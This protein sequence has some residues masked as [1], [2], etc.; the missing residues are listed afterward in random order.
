MKRGKNPTHGER[1]EL[2]AQQVAR[3]QRVPLSEAR[4]IVRADLQK[5]QEREHV[6]TAIEVRFGRKN[7]AT[8]A[9]APNPVPLLPPEPEQHMMA[10]LTDQQLEAAY[11]RTNVKHDAATT[12]EGRDQANRFL[13][14]YLWEA[15]RRNLHLDRSPSSSK[16]KPMRSS[17]PA[18]AHVN[19]RHVEELVLYAENTGELYA[20]KKELLGKARLHQLQGTYTVPWAVQQWT[21]WLSLAARMHDREFRRDPDRVHFTS[22]DIHAA[23]AE[24]EER[25]RH[26]MGS[27]E[28][29]WAMGELPGA[30]RASNPVDMTL[31]RGFLVRY[32]APS[33]A[34]LQTETVTQRKP[35]ESEDDMI[36]RLAMAGTDGQI[37][38]IDNGKGYVRRVRITNDGQRFGFQP[39]KDETTSRG[40]HIA[41]ADTGRA[42]NPVDLRDM[43]PVGTKN[44]AMGTRVTVTP[45]RNEHGE[46]VVRHWVDGKMVGE[47]FTT[48]QAD[49]EGT[50]RVMRGTHHGHPVPNEHARF[51]GE[52]RGANPVGTKNKAMGTRVTVTP[53]RDP[54]GDFVVRH[55]V[56]GKLVGEYFTTDHED[57]LATARVIRGTHHGHPVPGEG[58]RFYGEHRASNPISHEE[59]DFLAGYVETALWSSLDDDGHPLDR[60]HTVADIAHETLA[61]MEREAAA[62]F[63]ANRHDLEAYGSGWARLGGHDFWLTREGHGAGFWDG[64]WP[65]PQATRLTQAA[66]AYGE[67]NLYVGDDGKIYQGTQER[68]SNPAVFVQVNQQRRGHHRHHGHHHGLPHHEAPMLPAAASDCGCDGERRGNP[69][70]GYTD[71]FGVAWIPTPVRR[72]AWEEPTYSVVTGDQASGQV[73][74]VKSGY[75]TMESAQRYAY[76]RSQGLTDTDATALVHTDMAVDKA[77]HIGGRVA[78]GAAAL[79]GHGKRAAAA[80]AAKAKEAHA[81][82][83]AKKKAAPKKGGKKPA[84]GRKGNPAD[85]TKAKKPRKGKSTKDWNASINESDKAAIRQIVG[86]KHVGEPEN[87]VA[88]DMIRRLGKNACTPLGRQVV[89]YALDAH[90]ENYRT[91]AEVM[92]R[93]TLP[94]GRPSKGK[95]IAALV[96]KCPEAATAAA[97]LPAPR[98]ENPAKGK[99]AGKH[100]VKPWTY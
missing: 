32:Y 81:A 55:W 87:D 27:G 83:K 85:P 100:P 91:Y 25:F 72:A 98:S 63:A 78:A 93:V 90:Y 54:G 31:P 45:R 18:P 71:K 59:E 50:A 7:P 6:Q 11:A 33:G 94:K 75:K 79:F 23:A 3:E 82:Y 16:E 28:H 49:A 8:D 88:E 57:A 77:K 67:A 53:R 19:E 64:D 29:D 62:F 22:S 9:R 2:L 10:R 74:T 99:K 47:Y 58:S 13:C 48:D 42:A 46:F 24:L 68:S 37:L 41:Y 12:P 38:T 95:P 84:K 65:E 52:H 66:H 96:L 61:T 36:L 51:Y 56:D 60:N 4:S 35:K 70:D 97:A 34:A 26:E 76:W 80:A 15:Q 40:R 20:G 21:N 39:I 73:K 17:N 5:K 30:G 89:E 86:W 92:S 14:W 69:L 44:K 1:L 43:N